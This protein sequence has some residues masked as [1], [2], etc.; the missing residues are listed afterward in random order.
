MIHKH[1]LV[2]VVDDDE[3]VRKGLQYLLL[4]AGYQSAFYTSA[5]DFLTNDAP[6]VSGCAVL[7]IQMPNMTGLELFNELLNRDY[8]RPIIFLTGHGD[9]DTAVGAV[10]KGAFDFLQKP[11]DPER[12]IETIEKAIELDLRRRG[13][14]LTDF[15]LKELIDKLTQRER[16]IINFL[17]EDLSNKDI[18]ERLGLSSRTVENHRAAAYRKLSINS[19]QQLKDKIGPVKNHL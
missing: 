7:D 9:I 2:R 13:S 6:S 8:K 16:Q 19:L 14:N 17:M 5:I 3:S 15:E 10:K 18:A 4:A 1:A 12:F 11:I